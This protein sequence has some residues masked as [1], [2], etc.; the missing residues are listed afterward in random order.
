MKIPEIEKT[1][2][3]KYQDDLDSTGIEITFFKDELT[4]KKGGGVV[5]VLY[6]DCFGF[7]R[8]IRHSM[9][10]G[11]TER[12]ESSRLSYVIYPSGDDKYFVGSQTDSSGGSVQW[13]TKALMVVRDILY[14]VASIRTEVEE[15]MDSDSAIRPDSGPSTFEEPH[16]LV[17]VDPGAASKEQIADVLSDLS[18]LYEMEGGS[19]LSYSF[20]EVKILDHEE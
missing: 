11:R 1:I 10:S 9:K 3:E 16:L 5:H 17:I 15:E 20:D 19:G 6:N 4:F 14:K 2:R 8:I 12:F 18:I 13:N 7:E